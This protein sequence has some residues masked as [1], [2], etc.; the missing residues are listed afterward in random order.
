M[1]RSDAAFVGSVPENYDRYLAS[2]LFD[3][4]AEDLAAR[5]PVIDMIPAV[6]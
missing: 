4:Y 3:P 6:A 2:V 1:G 5:L